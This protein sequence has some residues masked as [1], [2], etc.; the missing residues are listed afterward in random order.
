MCRFRA[1]CYATNWRPAHCQ[2]SVL[3]VPLRALRAL[4]GELALAQFKSYL[5]PS[6]VAL[7]KHGSSSIVALRASTFLDHL[8]R[9][10]SGRLASVLPL[11]DWSASA[12]SQRIPGFSTRLACMCKNLRGT[13]VLSSLRFNGRANV[14]PHRTI[15]ADIAVCRR[16]H[17][18]RRRKNAFVFGQR[19]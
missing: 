8:Q 6:S 7:R 10:F 1:S 9:G 15:I 4:H 17:D 19:I 12:W 11:L 3:H 14:R 2:T 16:V 5:S 18:G 13:S